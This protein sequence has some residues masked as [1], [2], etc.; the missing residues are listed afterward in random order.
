M[1]TSWI[2]KANDGINGLK[3]NVERG[4]LEWFDEI[5][6]ACGDSTDT[7]SYTDFLAKG[8]L[9]GTIP[10]EVLDEARETVTRLNQAI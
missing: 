6:C 1:T 5:G 3:I 4:L 8:A 9:L 2:W 7:Q 10:S